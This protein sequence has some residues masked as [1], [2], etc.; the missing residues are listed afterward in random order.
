MHFFSIILFVISSNLDNF[1]IAAA[2]GIRKLKISIFSNLIFA[3]ISC[4]GTLLAMLL[5]KSMSYFISAKFTDIIGCIILISIGI[6]TIIDSMRKIPENSSKE[7]SIENL[8]YNYLIKN[9]EAADK[10]MSGYIDT[11]EAVLLGFA[12]ALNN[13]GMGFGAGA[14]GLNIFL[15]TVLTF[16]FSF[17]AIAVGY[18]L[19]QNCLSKFI[20]RCGGIISGLIIIFIGIY[21]FLT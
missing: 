13:I 20:G 5:G 14:A 16:V 18:I 7:N 21:E 8:S 10:D 19:G 12:L 2:Y 4:L 17:I 9:P 6:W 3:A 15:T 11:K 1:M